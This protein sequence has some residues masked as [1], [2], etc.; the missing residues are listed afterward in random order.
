MHPDV[1]AFVSELSYEG[2]LESAAG[3]ERQAISGEGLLV[4]GGSALGAGGA[5][6]TIGR[7]RRGG[8]GRRRPRQGT[9]DPVLDR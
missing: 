3:R 9:P 1:T 6:G 4:R 2:R 8:C 7:E 5:R